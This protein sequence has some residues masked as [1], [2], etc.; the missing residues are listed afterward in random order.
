MQV[1]FTCN[2]YESCMYSVS[3]IAYTVIQLIVK[4]QPT[5]NTWISDVSLRSY[6]RGTVNT[7][8]Y[9]R[10]LLTIDTAGLHVAP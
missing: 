1:L 3:F 8:Y 2:V 7:T 6:T 10:C 4:S 5:C 9:F